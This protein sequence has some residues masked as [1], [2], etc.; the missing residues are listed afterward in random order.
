MARSDLLFKGLLG[1]LQD[2]IRFKALSVSK[3]YEFKA[4]VFN[5]KPLSWK[6]NKLFNIGYHKEIMNDKFT[7]LAII[8]N[9]NPHTLH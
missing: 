5:G 2:R 4:I 3:E 9:Y 7:L 1:P 8:I 6:L